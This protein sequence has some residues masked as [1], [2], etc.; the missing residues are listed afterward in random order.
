[1]SLSNNNAIRHRA[2]A[3]R[4]A[5]RVLVNSVAR[6]RAGFSVATEPWIALPAEFQ[7]T[8]LGRA[9]AEALSSSKTDLLLPIDYKALKAARLSAAGVRSERQFMQS[10]QF[11]SIESDG[12]G[13]SF[14]PSRNAGWLGEQKGFHLL[15][16]QTVRVSI[17]ADSAALGVALAKAWSLCQ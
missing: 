3:Y 14:T 15:E 9:L 12:S 6:T 5:N 2:D 13:I 4:W 8:E 11:V 1:M 7:P 17:S 10:V 16:N